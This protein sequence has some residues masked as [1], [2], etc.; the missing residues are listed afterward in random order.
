MAHTGEMMMPVNAELAQQ[1]AA[2]LWDP[3]ALLAINFELVPF[4]C[5]QCAAS[6]CGEH[7]RTEMVFEHDPLPAWLDSI[8]GECPYGHERM[9]ED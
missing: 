6:Y 5:P 7:W 3:A 2:V 8:R 1:I 4:W 9:L